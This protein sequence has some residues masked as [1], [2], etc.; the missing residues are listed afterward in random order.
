M[1]RTAGLVA[2]VVAVGAAAAAY[3]WKPWEGRAAMAEPP[4]LALPGDDEPKRDKF[5]QDKGGAQLKDI[6]FDGTRAMKYLKQLCDIGPRVSGSEGMKKQQE[7]VI[8][9]LEKVGGKVTKQEFEA[10]QYSRRDKVAMTNLVVAWFPDR[11]RRVILSTHYDTRPMAHEEPNRQAWSKPFTSAND[12]TSG[13]AFLMELAH[14]MKDYPTTFGVD[15]VLFDGEEY[16]FEPG[17]PMGGGDRFFFG[18]DHFA[19]EY[20][21]HLARHKYRYE[22]ALLFDLFAHSGAVFK[23]EGNSYAFAPKLAEQVWKVADAVGVKSFEWKEGP[24]ITDDHLALNRAGIPAVDVIDFEG[25]R[26]NWHR[27]SDTPDKCSDKQFAEVAKVVTAW[28]Q[29]IR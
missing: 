15:F 1:T 23:V 25:Y 21:K 27:L 20:K 18:S 19:D 13:V 28:L 2:A 10:K 11:P 17:G 16:I 6:P 9:H 4:S 14:H 29:W 3:A 12:G 8:A 24:E 22:A 5:A 26:P 7:L